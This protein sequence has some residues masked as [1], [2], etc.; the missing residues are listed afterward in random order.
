M[1]Q[2]HGQPLAQ[3]AQR[4]PPARRLARRSKGVHWEL[5]DDGTRPPYTNVPTAWE[6]IDDGSLSSGLGASPQWHPRAAVP[7]QAR[8]RP[9]SAPDRQASA[10]R[11][12]G[13]A[14]PDQ[15]HFGA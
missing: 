10:A 9:S 13:H 11:R 12:A 4:T 6:L 5:S 3:H 15:G 14:V 8:A 7:R 1:L 2:Q